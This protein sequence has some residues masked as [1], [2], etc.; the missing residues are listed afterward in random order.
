MPDPDEQI[1]VDDPVM[2]QGIH[3]HT[4]EQPAFQLPPG[5]M[6]WQTQ[7]M[8]TTVAQVMQAMPPPQVNIHTPA[9]PPAAPTSSGI[10]FRFGADSPAFSG[11]SEDARPYVNQ[12][13]D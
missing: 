6:E 13:W 10:Q 1:P 11:K 5:F 8:A 2:S 3:S 12:I 9:V 4:P 7:L